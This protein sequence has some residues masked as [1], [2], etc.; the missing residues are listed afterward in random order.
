MNRFKSNIVQ[1]SEFNN[2]NLR[3][4]SNFAIQIVRHDIH[5]PRLTRASTEKEDVKTM[6]IIAWHTIFFLVHQNDKGNL[7]N[8]E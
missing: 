8:T 3:N 2:E 6:P 1:K 5:A 4:S 7:H